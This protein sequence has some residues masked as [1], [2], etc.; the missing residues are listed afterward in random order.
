M[1]ALSK[2]LS[3][4]AS[5]VPKGA[6]VCDVG[7]DHGYLSIYLR[8]SGTAQGVIA[9]DINEKPLKTARKNIKESQ[10]GGIE[11]RL[12]DGLSAVNKG[13]IDTAVIAGMG[14]EVISGILK[15]GKDIAK[16]GITLILQPTTSPEFLRKFLSENGYEIL[17]EIP[18]LENR[19]LYSVML[20]TF[21]GKYEKKEEYYY[22]IGALTADTDEGKR[23][24]EK[25]YNRLFKCLTALENVPSKRSEYLSLKEISDNLKRILEGNG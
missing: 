24:I 11:L 9:S 16:S 22:Y 4:I 8:S 1:Q 3:V 19:K 20:C 23:Y 2:R 21:T 6:R 25:Q 18:V 15:R 14:G 10:I 12:G 17:K 5:L 7:T 13:E